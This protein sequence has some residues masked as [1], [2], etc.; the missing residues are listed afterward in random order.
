MK[1]K[2]NLAEHGLSPWLDEANDF[3]FVPLEGEGYETIPVKAL[4]DGTFRVCCVPFFVYD[5][6]QGDVVTKNTAD[7]LL[8]I[9]SKSGNCDFR[10]RSEEGQDTI[11]AIVDVLE[12]AGTTVEFEPWGRLVCVSV[13]PAVDA[14]RISGY[15]QS[16]EE[17]GTLRYEAVASAPAPTP[18]PHAQKREPTVVRFDR[19]GRLETDA[20][21]V[22][23]EARRGI[24]FPVSYR[25]AVSSNDGAYLR[26]SLVWVWNPLSRRNECI[27]CA[28]LI[29]FED[30]GS[31]EMTMDES[32]TDLPDFLDGIVSFGVEGG[33]YLFAF[34][35]RTCKADPPVVLLHYGTVLDNV[36]QILPVAESFEEFLTKLRPDRTEDEESSDSAA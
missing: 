34:D 32:H 17:A 14:S 4:G 35:Y 31:G 26:P 27:S 20:A 22:A 13:P 11:R 10:F 36:L 3:V 33:G 7:I 30:Q 21:I 5:L 9:R 8:E 18:W 1:L 28:A 29:P 24:R 16:L 12:G 25:N 19:G 6:N 15:L 2:P 23:F